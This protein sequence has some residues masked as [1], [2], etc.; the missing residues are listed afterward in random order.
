MTAPINVTAVKCDIRTSLAVQRLRLPLPMQGALFRS[1]VGED[2][3][4]LVVRFKKKKDISGIN[5]LEKSLLGL[6]P[7][8]SGAE[9]S[10]QYKRCEFNP[11]PGKIPHA[12]E[13]LSPCITTTEP[14]L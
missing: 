6:L 12:L 11:L 4:C 2:P 13:Q 7:G 9:S 8:L 1:L 5:W 10:C 3:I 14:A